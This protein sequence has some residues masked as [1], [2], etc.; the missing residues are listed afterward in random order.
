[1]KLAANKS[2]SN[3]FRMRN[4]AE[5]GNWIDLAANSSFSLNIIPGCSLISGSSISIPLQ[6][7]ENWIELSAFNQFEFND[8]GMN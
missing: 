4:G 8:C 5:I 7:N 6:L 2:I 3:N 1:M